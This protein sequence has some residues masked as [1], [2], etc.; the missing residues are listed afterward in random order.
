M[1]NNKAKA[2]A[3]TAEAQEKANAFSYKTGDRAWRSFLKE[4][5]VVPSDFTLSDAKKKLGVSK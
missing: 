3:W 2:G 4:V 1:K 5:G